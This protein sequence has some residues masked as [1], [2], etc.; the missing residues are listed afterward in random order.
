ME[1]VAGSEIDRATEKCFDVFPRS[2]EFYERKWRLHI[3]VD[4]HVDI[5]LGPKFIAGGGTEQIKAFSVKRR[6]SA[7]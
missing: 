1:A 6:M 3:V 2:N 5:A 7:S 4:E